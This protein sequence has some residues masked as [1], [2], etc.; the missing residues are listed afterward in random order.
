MEVALGAQKVDIVAVGSWQD[1]KGGKKQ[2]LW[3]LRLLQLVVVARKKRAR[4]I[5]VASGPGKT[6]PEWQ[7]KTQRCLALQL[8]TAQARRWPR[9]K[10]RS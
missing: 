1:N 8:K 3:R 7:R 10:K 4:A 6:M 2:S 5:L 9:K